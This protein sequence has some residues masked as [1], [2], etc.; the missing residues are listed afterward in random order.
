M[1]FI[2]QFPDDSSK[3]SLHKEESLHHIG[4]DLLELIEPGNEERNNR[5]QSST[6]S[7]QKDDT[8]SLTDLEEQAEKEV[9]SLTAN[10]PKGLK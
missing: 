10:R 2:H 8:Q 5:K 6:L 9:N 4:T 3:G 1:I 7:K